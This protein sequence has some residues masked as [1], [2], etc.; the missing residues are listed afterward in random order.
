MRVKSGKKV[1]TKL[2]K[3]ALVANNASFGE[4]QNAFKSGAKIFVK[5]S[6]SVESNGLETSE[7][8]GA[9]SHTSKSVVATLGFAAV[10]LSGASAEA[11]NAT[12]VANITNTTNGGKNVTIENKE[13]DGNIYGSNFTNSSNNSVTLKNVTTKANGTQDG[14]VW[15]G[16]YSA[17]N[18][19]GDSIGNIINI[20]DGSVINGS[21]I[22]GASV[23][24]TNTQANYTNG[25]KGASSNQ[26]FIKGTAGKKVEVKSGVF[27][28]AGAGKT[29]ANNN[30]ITLEYVNVSGATQNTSFGF[31]PVLN[32]TVT[33]EVAGTVL[34]GVTYGVAGVANNK[35]NAK[36]SNINGSLIG[37]GALNGFLEN[38]S[39]YAEN[40]TIGGNV[41]GGYNINGTG[42]VNNSGT[43]N[44]TFQN[45][46]SY[47]K[48]SNVTLHNVNV[49][50]GTDYKLLGFQFNT[51]GNV[52][53]GVAGSLSATGNNVTITG[54]ST[55]H[56]IVV[57][58]G[59]FGGYVGSFANAQRDNISS[60]AVNSTT[61]TNISFKDERRNI[62][63]ITGEKSADGSYSVKVKNAV[64]GGVN[65]GNSTLINYAANS[66]TSG[67]DGST[68]NTTTNGT[69]LRHVGILGNY[70]FLKN[71]NVSGETRNA[72]FASKLVFETGGVVAGGLNYGNAS[73]IKF[74]VVQADNAWIGGTVIGGGS[75]GGNASE[76]KVNLT[77]SLVMGS[78]YG[79]YNINAS[80]VGTTNGSGVTL[81]VK[82][83]ASSSDKSVVY[84][85]NVTT[86]GGINHTL[87]GNFIVSEGNV[88][89]GHAGKGGASDNNVTII[90][91]YIGGSVFGGGSYFGSSKGNLVNVSKS[92]ISG[93]VFGSVS[94]GTFDVTERF[95]GNSLILD[96][97]NVTGNRTHF[98]LFQPNASVPTE[99]NPFALQVGGV[100]AGI[101]NFGSSVVQG[102]FSIDNNSL[103]DA[104]KSDNNLA[105]LLF[106][107]TATGVEVSNS[108]LKETLITAGSLN[109]SIYRTAA[110]VTNT[111]VGGNIYGA[112]NIDP[113]GNYTAAT[114]TVAGGYTSNVSSHFANHL[115][116]SGVETQGGS[117]FTF[118][119]A[120]SSF[121]LHTQG[122][123]IGSFS[124]KESVANTIFINDSVANKKSVINGSVVASAS[125]GSTSYNNLVSV[126]GINNATRTQINGGVFGSLA[127]S[128]STY[129]QTNT[130]KAT[131]VGLNSKNII[132]ALTNQLVSNMSIGNADT[133][134]TSEN[135][136][137]DLWKNGT[138]VR[139]K[140]VNVTGTTDNLT[141]GRKEAGN[142]DAGGVIAAAFVIG[143]T[144]ITRANV[145]LDNVWTAGSIIG[146]WGTGGGD[147]GLFNESFWNNSSWL[148]NTQQWAAGN[149]SATPNTNDTIGR[150]IHAV[151]FGMF[152]N[153][154]NTYSGG[155]VRGAV[156]AA[157][158]NAAAFVSLKDSH[159]VGGSTSGGQSLGI[160]I[161][162]KGDVIGATSVN[163][164][165]S[166]NVTITASTQGS[167]DKKTNSS[168]YIKGDVFGALASG[169]GS[170]IN[171]N[172]T[173]TNATVGGKVIGG[174]ANGTGNASGNNV[175]IINS[176]INQNFSNAD[177]SSTSTKL[178]GVSKVNST[179]NIAV[180]GGYSKDG[181]AQNNSINIVN[182]TIYGHI[183]VSYQEKNQYTNTNGQSASV[184]VNQTGDVISGNGSI[185]SGDI[186]IKNSVLIGGS[187]LRVCGNVSETIS[188]NQVV[189]D[190]SYVGNKNL[191]NET[192]NNS[193]ITD[194]N[195]TGNNN[196]IKN[197]TIDKTN[198]SN[199]NLS[200]NNFSN[201]NIT[202]SNIT[203][204]NI[205]GSNVTDSNLSKD[206]VTNSN[207]TNTTLNNSNVSNNNISNSTINSSNV[208]NNTIKN[209]STLN[210]SNVTNNN[211]TDSV[212]N[213]S[214]VTENNVTNSTIDNSNVT[215]NNISN[216]T[217]NNSNVTENNIT[218]TI[219]NNSNVSNN[220]LTNTT[221]ENSNLTNGT[222]VMINATGGSICDA[223]IKG[224]NLANIYLCRD[225]ISNSNITDQSVVEAT[226]VTNSNISDSAVMNSTFSGSNASKTNFSNA[227]INNSNL[228]G[229]TVTGGKLNNSNVTNSLLSN[230]TL[231]KDNVTNITNSTIANSVLNQTNF[232]K[233]NFTNDTISQSN[234][235]ESNITGG[236]INNDSASNIS[237]N[238]ISNA[239]L[240]NFVF[241]GSANTNKYTGNTINNSTITNP[242]SNSLNGNNI[243]NSNVT[244]LNGTGI[245]INFNKDGQTNQL[246]NVKDTNI[247]MGG[248]CNAGNISNSNF[249]GAIICNASVETSNITQSSISNA[250][251]T[252]SNLSMSQYNN[253]NVSNSNL[254]GAINTTG[255]AVLDKVTLS[256]VNIKDS[257]VTVAKGENNARA[258]IVLENNT[259]I[260]NSNLTLVEANKGVANATITVSGDVEFDNSVIGAVSNQSSAWVN[261]TATGS[262]KG[263]I[264]GSII[265]AEAKQ[266]GNATAFINATGANVGG[267]ITGAKT[268]TG[269]AYANITATEANVQGAVI[270][271]TTTSGNAEAFISANGA[272]NITSVI[273]ATTD[274]GNATGHINATKA[275]I[276]NN[277][278]GAV[279]K[280]G[281]AEGFIHLNTSMI[282]GD[283]IGATQTGDG[284]I[285][286]SVR[287]DGSEVGG[288]VIGAYSKNGG[289]ANNSVVTFGAPNSTIKGDIYG[290]L[291]N[292]STTNATKDKYHASNNTVNI[293]A[294]LS[295]V[296][297]TIFG[298]YVNV[299]DSSK[300]GDVINNRLII[301]SKN[302]EVK[303]I[304]DFQ[305]IDFYLPKDIQDKDVMLNLRGGGKTDLANVSYSFGVADGIIDALEPEN[306]KSQ[307]TVTLISKANGTLLLAPESLQNRVT[308]GGLSN[309]YDH[310]YSLDA[311]NQK[312]DL[313]IKRGVGAQQ[314]AVF[315]AALAGVAPVVRSQDVI[316][317]MVYRMEPN[318]DLTSSDMLTGNIEAGKFKS[319][320]GS[321]VSNTNF[322]LSV[323]VG[324]NSN[325]EFY[326]GAFLDAGFGSY[327]T[328]NEAA[329]GLEVKGGGDNMHIGVGAFAKW[330]F[331]ANLDSTFYTTA[332]VGYSKL[333][334]W[335]DSYKNGNFL[336]REVDSS[337]FKLSRIYFGLTGEAAHRLGSYWYDGSFDAFARLSYLGVTSDDVKL[338]REDFTVDA[339]HSLTARVGFRYTETLNEAWTSYI[340][341][342]FEREFLG[343]S[344]GTNNKQGYALTDYITAPTMKG[345]SGVGEIGF[346]YDTKNTQ[347]GGFV[348]N[349]K[350][351]GSV[352]TNRGWG[353]G[354]DL[355]YRF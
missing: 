305:F 152:V 290:G 336:R 281:S 266:G 318:G 19:S 119:G 163:G 63:N 242:L 117:N 303:D 69:L 114:G 201:S 183:C 128:N 337:D 22:G 231:T 209:N 34:G 139:L 184:G 226:N 299:S 29:V 202:D 228:N 350:L 229:S 187:F 168:T 16:N 113:R 125:L 312:L 100:A 30:T 32:Q 42:A 177:G 197:N 235:S 297:S 313:T 298:G 3:D 203:D 45:N 324:R 87:L 199:S 346:T 332:R 347:D 191:T 319:Y 317:D 140:N 54:N 277:I 7:V 115:A 255:D 130:S 5:N 348:I 84:L 36:H 158:G 243:T 343:E 256:G 205:T 132:A 286:G 53:G 284:D 108:N 172:V 340:S 162:T 265:G 120:N 82:G 207:V 67:I 148:N 104:S 279:T 61:Y 166:A 150:G 95:K 210:N 196:T 68:V 71:V 267:N 268:N 76:N 200:N 47:V 10:A 287:V 91:S 20:T 190:S 137:E 354:F 59:S 259:V 24:G 261:L 342:A 272:K 331:G 206:N 291:V 233:L 246:V 31:V 134:S 258:N 321:Y 208:T 232:T 330:A 220:N 341:A 147:V 214:N 70:V 39:I 73:F 323:G 223:N 175:T 306:V 302:V 315:E 155:N 75:S 160:N 239:T 339:T 351:L 253:V 21:V 129:D 154:S 188:G 92:N 193:T 98:T 275:Y 151:Q 276:A 283:V 37:G 83:D 167:K 111:T 9:L 344:S 289:D 219:I 278:Y 90:D 224:D 142:F 211:I 328:Y 106:N 135:V 1:A 14:S 97:V 13:V 40:T 8:F 99:K 249:V 64:I 26:V 174:Y 170:A 192:I 189:I 102:R 248:V 153:V 12:G 251:V 41:Y 329:R 143:N 217:I 335:A 33:L 355:K 216:S 141:F 222:F 60:D 245:F 282:G 105:S 307:M 180:I 179:D 112:F 252:S 238:N 56:G 215:H 49:T 293:S 322:G 55:I 78:I 138:Q 353:G 247:T 198:V 269:N 4:G 185:D 173:I 48:G 308:Y 310:I 218:N 194:S 85:K 264:N 169:N 74:N 349:F 181:L 270:G 225:N 240:N 237:G 43:V 28:G 110:V 124:S 314:K 6:K 62:V 146:G 195:I 50:G 309:V 94:Y 244:G 65:I 145:E 257:N 122:N 234:I 295:A 101:I 46:N 27:G 79:S 159:I 81:Q 204:S 227:D 23:N 260:Q 77:N 157:G 352:G 136:F 126:S 80:G 52:F 149:T 254:T 121:M 221:V 161:T 127:F 334:F 292:V 285:S 17:V 178:N 250:N 89:G 271:A 182:S 38:N 274:S 164:T 144:S 103:Y 345:N 304:Q 273:G 116:L 338:P 2:K 18:S 212:I 320:T 263:F 326:Y 86:V 123:V 280:N 176:I 171:S 294:P 311:N 316:H 262:D 156:A 131:F 213:N 118:G 133:I 333:D 186:K 107:K 58:G 327:E 93:G 296:N 165:A 66:T 300:K 288:N 230:L 241:T 88:W 236:V 15:G 35:I 25:D 301:A 109:G 44:Y 325:D 51:E 57:G 11:F 72:T 96:G